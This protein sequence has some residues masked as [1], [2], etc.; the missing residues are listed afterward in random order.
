MMLV[1]PEHRRRGIGRELFSAALD[2]LCA[3]GVSTVKLDATPAGRSLYEAFGFV[4]ESV[5]ERW[6][7]VAQDNLVNCDQTLHAEIWQ[8][9]YTL[10][11]SVFGADRTRVLEA[12]ITDSVVAP[13]AIMAG[14][15]LQGYALA[16]SGLAASY[17]GPIIAQDES[18]ALELLDRMLDQLRGQKVYL[19][20][21]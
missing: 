14:G 17:V 2:H 10:D 13:Q 20:F 12:L 3:S 15:R 18:T 8:K 19:D 9:M 16:R 7:T 5:I 6:E 1:A 4:H 11:Q 21:H